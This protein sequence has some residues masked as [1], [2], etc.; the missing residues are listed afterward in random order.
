MNNDRQLPQEFLRMIESYNAPRLAELKGALLTEPTVSVRLNAAKGAVAAT[1]YDRVPWCPQGLY[2]PQRHQFTFDPA[3][4]QGLYYVQ[5]A[6]SMFVAHAAGIITA[7]RR[8]RKVLDACAA[9]G[10]KTTALID[11]LPAGSGV[12]ANEWDT[13]RAAI[14]RENLTKWGYPLVTVTQGDTSRFT[15]MTGC[16]DIIVA[17]VPCSGEG[18]MRK[19]PEAVSQWS[20]Q[21][22]TQ[23]AARQREIIDKLW[24][25]LAP[26]GHLIYSTCTFN[27]DENELTIDYIAST[28]GAESVELP[29]SPSWGIIPA[30][31]SRHHCYRFIPGLTRGEGLFMAVLRK[32]ELDGGMPGGRQPGNRQKHTGRKPAPTVPA[33]VR[34]WVEGASEWRLEDGRVTASFRPVAGEF[35]LKC[36]L[37][38]ATVKGRDYLPTQALAMSTALRRGA[39]A[40]HEVDARTAIDYLS[41]RTVTLDVAPRGI[42]LLTYGGRPLGFVKNLGSRANNLYPK[43]WRILS[44]QATPAPAPF[45]SAE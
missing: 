22:V 14:L 4:H 36:D 27:R 9:P 38:V 11:A 43:A 10:G 12:V 37:E 5:D 21:L 35:P 31:G 7:D 13:R 34:E 3:W 32:P 39:F 8:P 28:Y 1:G 40:E 16:F 6:S 25:A 41:C 30:I 24:P 2:L 42:V 44:Q 17:D 29:V 19:D 45:L 20:P 15:A 23:C 26:G 33:E 18:M